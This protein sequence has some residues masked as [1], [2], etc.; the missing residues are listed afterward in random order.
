MA[1]RPPTISSSETGDGGR[2]SATQPHF[3]A[4][5]KKLI[6]TFR[7]PGW[8]DRPSWERAFEFL[9]LINAELS[10]V[11]NDAYAGSLFYE[12]AR[13]FESELNDDDAA[14]VCLQAGYVCDT[15]SHR[16]IQMAR[17]VFVRVERWSMVC[18]FI[19]AQA[20]LAQSNEKRGLALLELGEVFL[21]RFKRKE[22][23]LRCARKAAHLLKDHLIARLLRD[24]VAGQFGKET[25][26]TDAS[27]DVIAID[28]RL[29]VEEN[30]LSVLDGLSA[31]HARM[32]S[33][34]LLE[35]DDYLDNHSQLIHC[36]LQAHSFAGNWDSYCRLAR[37]MVSQVHEAEYR[38]L[39]NYSLCFFGRLRGLDGSVKESYLDQLKRSGI[40]CHYFEELYGL[41]ALDEGDIDAASEH[42]IRASVES[43][44]E[45]WTLHY[46]EHGLFLRCCASGSRSDSASE[47]AERLIVLNSSNAMGQ[48]AS[49]QGL[50]A[51]R[52]WTLL[53]SR[54]EE[55]QADGHAVNQVLG[56][57]RLA[58]LLSTKLS[59]NSL[60]ES[61]FGELQSNYPR[62]VAPLACLIELKSRTSDHSEAHRL[63]EENKTVLHSKG[64]LDV[65]HCI[66]I[67]RM[68]GSYF[69][70][71]PAELP[72]SLH[73]DPLGYVLDP[74]ETMATDAQSER[75]YR[76][77][78][79]RAERVDDPSYRASFLR[80][81]SLLSESVYPEQPEIALNHIGAALDC[82]PNDIQSLHIGYRLCASSGQSRRSADWAVRIANACIVD[83]HA[84]EYLGFAGHHTVRQTPE[85]AFDLWHEALQR[86]PHNIAARLGLE[87]LLANRPMSLESQ[88]YY[89]LQS[90]HAPSAPQR[91]HYALM[92]QYAGRVRDERNP[93]QQLSSQGWLDSAGRRLCLF[94]EH[95]SALRAFNDEAAR[96]SL[97]G[98]ADSE[99]RRKDRVTCLN[100]IARS[101]E[102]AGDSFS[103]YDSV[104]QVLDAEPTNRAALHWVFAWVM[105]TADVEVLSTHLDSL[106]DARS[107]ED[108]RGWLWSEAGRILRLAGHEE[109][110]ANCY[111]AAMKAMPD[112][113]LPVYHLR[114]VAD[115]A[116]QP[117][118]SAHLM[119]DLATK[120]RANLMV[121]DV[122][123]DASERFL[124]VGQ[125]RDAL[126]ALML[127]YRY[128]PSDESLLER[129][130]SQA[131]RLADWDTLAKAL[132]IAVGIDSL[133]TVERVLKLV[134]TLSS[135]LSRTA[136]G[137]D[138]L[139]RFAEERA[140]P[141]LWQALADYYVDEARWTEAVDSY[142]R[143]HTLT[144]DLAL[145]RAIVFRLAAIYSSQLNEYDQARR[146]LET[147]LDA[148]GGDLDILNCLAGVERRA[149]HKH[150]ERLALARALS[151][152]VDEEQRVRFQ[153]RLA[154]LDNED[155]R[156]EM[157]T[158]RLR[159][160]A[161]D[162]SSSPDVNESL[163]DALGKQ[164]AKDEQAVLLEAALNLTTE[165][166]DKR[167]LSEKLL[168]TG[169]LDAA[170]PAIDLLRD[171]TNALLKNPLNQDAVLSLARACHSRDD[172][173]SRQM[174]LIAQVLCSEY[175]SKGL[176][177]LKPLGAAHATIQSKDAKP[178]GLGNLELV[179]A[180]NTLCSELPS[181]YTKCPNMTPFSSPNEHEYGFGSIQVGTVPQWCF[182]QQTDALCVS[183]E[184]YD[185]DSGLQGFLFNLADTYW[186][187]QAIFLSRWTNDGLIEV[188]GS[189][190]DSLGINPSAG[191]RAGQGSGLHRLLQKRFEQA[192]PTAKMLNALSILTVHFRDLD[193]YLEQLRL[194]IWLTCIN[195]ETDLV[196]AIKLLETWSNTR[197]AVWRS[198]FQ[199]LLAG[200]IRAAARGLSLNNQIM[201]GG[202]S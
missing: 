157:A 69:E 134:N 85:R 101:F 188:V 185:L 179:V 120:L 118:R 52:D 62:S 24:G 108:E 63:F 26:A 96:A 6:E 76:A 57:W 192:R 23:A 43:E 40:R 74:S 93:T 138:T 191:T 149:G 60:A 83:R 116:G 109:Q 99:M 67:A 78:L 172:P 154:E 4:D 71:E 106:L 31:G 88:A 70:E 72:L 114:T 33:S 195:N 187:N 18:T 162:L 146:W 173:R 183:R 94:H 79:A 55:M 194:R 1:S 35:A 100:A 124:S 121:S 184:L 132:E 13:I 104:K 30:I 15:K 145:R 175:G 56:T 75:L 9:Q 122:A 68:F 82:K 8:I 53:K 39:L 166:G 84:S 190:N 44:S 41:V 19:E 38:A 135:R 128:Q 136:D 65:G 92:S 51:R 10:E 156:H 66:R 182:F 131:E 170:G 178:V 97:L 46:L 86:N 22:E 37:R 198:Q 50:I 165:P 54:F 199:T 181:V 81:A 11:E 117:A 168:T 151:L 143:A 161:A 7:R 103:G 20:R 163:A 159:R 107:N 196:S 119:L 127:A 90:D 17:R 171:A 164:N 27:V 14:I 112:S 126:K 142:T 189:F 21:F 25:A 174:A 150:Q 105:E 123:I 153:I 95:R 80:F 87:S 12:A 42:F 3:V 29:T 155:N 139:A 28:R 64:V 201:N 2:V 137:I 129:L 91:L 133:C 158:G 73:D 98:L 32:L 34:Q 102:R 58:L 115:K 59:Q 202:A 186:N 167:R 5:A 49:Q 45:Q 111:E 125:N 140:Q 200:L 176:P 180:L 141:N 193:D 16:I 148:H 177:H 47:L 36:A 77:M 160:A 152:T 61:L 48:W 110:A 144:S 169:R 130:Q 89:N 147:E 113:W 197:S